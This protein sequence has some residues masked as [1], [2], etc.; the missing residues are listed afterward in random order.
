M[1]IQLNLLLIQTEIH[2]CSDREPKQAW[3]GFRKE[4]VQRPLLALRALRQS[5]ITA[6]LPCSAF[7]A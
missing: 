3:M 6:H 1:H 4:A 2:L 5:S 7:E